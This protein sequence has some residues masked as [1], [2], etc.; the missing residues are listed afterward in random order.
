[1]QAALP[2]YVDVEDRTVTT[3]K[4]VRSGKIIT[5]ITGLDAVARKRFLKVLASLPS[6]PQRGG[7]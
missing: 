6:L 2:S 1:M 4:E 5:R 7:L 3:G